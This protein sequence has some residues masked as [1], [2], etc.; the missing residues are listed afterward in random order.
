MALSVWSK[1]KM[2]S[3]AFKEAF[4]TA[5]LLDSSEFEDFGG[6]QLRYEILWAWYEN[7]AYRNTHKWA[8]A[9]RNQY[10]LY[11]HIRNIYNPTHRLVEFW[12]MITWGG[13]L[14]ET[15]SE[16]GAIPIRTDND[17]L[18]ASIALLWDWS[19]WDMNKDVAT[20]Y[21]SALGD[22]ALRIADD[23]AHEEVRIEIVHP[24]TIADWEI[25]RRG[26]VKSYTIEE[27]RELKGRSV[28]Y[29]ETAE[30]GGGDDVIFKTYANNQLFPWNGVA[31]EW[32]EPYGFIPLIAVQHNRVGKDFG[33]SE[34][35]ALRS[36]AS[37][38]DDLA[39]K[40]HDYIRKVVDPVW[41]FNF[42]KPKKS[43]DTS[44]EVAAATANRPDPAR[45]EIPALYASHPHATAQPLVTD[46]IDVEK[47]SLAI[48]KIIEEM[49]RDYPELQMDIW[50]VG[51]YTTGRAL[52]TARQRVEKK[53]T[54]RRPNYD[55]PLIR[56]HQMAIAIAGWRKIKGFEGFDLTSYKKGDLAH[57]IPTDRPVF[58]ISALE[59]VERKKNF[60]SIVGEAKEKGLPINMVLKDL[61]WSDRKIKEYMVEQDKI[62]EEEA[63]A[64]AEFEEQR[65]DETSEEDENV[66]EG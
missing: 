11:K 46:M 7:T 66:D 63:E 58:E 44:M 8:Q 2:A 50:T 29:K 18:R 30:R 65:T 57:T 21:G 9:Y 43:A 37:E 39:S 54:Q 60:W 51:G 17:S 62:L 61:G 34:V 35:H 22:V 64:A 49:E 26:Y 56:A 48:S 20:M 38:V 40:L 32:I 59:A 16:E 5:G 55:K 45:E 31:A 3:S 33:W 42:R 24:S 13:L 4:V 10:S 14:S 27:T 23:P 41:L 15:A 28:T 12:K 52:Q 19:N 47:T 53:V 1:L 6:R 25:D 36:K